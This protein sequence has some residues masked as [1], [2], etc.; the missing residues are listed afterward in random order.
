VVDEVHMNEWLTQ[1]KDQLRE[2]PGSVG[3]KTAAM[4]AAVEMDRVLEAERP[5]WADYLR[6]LFEVWIRDKNYLISDLGADFRLP[7]TVNKS[8]AEVAMEYDL[9]TSNGI[10]E[11]QL[12]L[13]NAAEVRVQ[14]ALDHLEGG[15]SMQD[16][17]CFICSKQEYRQVQA[18]QYESGGPQ[19][20]YA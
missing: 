10:K 16:I 3:Q 15:W 19:G 12:R 11:K 6:R 2:L 18:G 9:H 20:V 8:D 14:R 17:V 7:E 5:K 13:A 1:I 4:V